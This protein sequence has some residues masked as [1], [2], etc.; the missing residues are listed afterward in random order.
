MEEGVFSS[1][2]VVSSE[3]SGNDEKDAYV[4]SFHVLPNGGVTE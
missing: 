3:A 1:V 2:W 4:F